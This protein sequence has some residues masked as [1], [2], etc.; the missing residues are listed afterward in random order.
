MSANFAAAT[1]CSHANDAV[2]LRPP[3][4]RPPAPPPLGWRV[5]V[6]GP[7]PTP[8]AARRPLPSRQRAGAMRNS[9]RPS[10]AIPRLPLPPPGT[11]RTAE[12]PPSLN[13]DALVA[14][15]TA[16]VE[17]RADVDDDTLTTMQQ[18]DACSSSK[19]RGAR[20]F[21][22][23]CGRTC[24]WTCQRGAQHSSAASGTRDSDVVD[25]PMTPL[26]RPVPDAAVPAAGGLAAAEKSARSGRCM[27]I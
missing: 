21:A 22:Q 16:S 14:L 10:F 9:Q 7:A 13:E 25:A 26:R 12:L 18:R 24:A 20:D 19:A 3:L 17:S 27:G 5:P 1:A 15:I 11:E 23:L 2:E 6:R 4:P 8:R